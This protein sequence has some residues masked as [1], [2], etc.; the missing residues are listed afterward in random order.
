MKASTPA[1]IAAEMQK[2]VAQGNPTKSTLHDGNTN[3]TSKESAMSKT[4][5]QV[6]AQPRQTGREQFN[7]L[8]RDRLAKEI[9]ADRKRFGLGKTKD[10]PPTIDDLEIPAWITAQLTDKQLAEVADPILAKLDR[11]SVDLTF[12]RLNAE[13]NAL[14]QLHFAKTVQPALDHTVPEW[15]TEPHPWKYD[16]KTGAATRYLGIATTPD[17]TGGIA[18]EV[19]ATQHDDGTLDFT[20]MI[21]CDPKTTP[22]GIRQAAA[23][24]MIL[25]DKYEAAQSKSRGRAD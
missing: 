11:K 21:D 15:C 14:H 17:R 9:A 20:L 12:A 19:S 8:K 5:A 16:I 2:T 3:P 10:A 1:R 25:A 24:L 22:A 7:A 6:T 18:A 23:D 4:T 13:R